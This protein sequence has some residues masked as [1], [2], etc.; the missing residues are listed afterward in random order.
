[1][2]HL[3]LQHFLNNY[4]E[5]SGISWKQAINSH[6]NGSQTRKAS[7]AY[8]VR[9]SRKLPELLVDF[10]PTENFRIRK[11]SANFA[12]HVNQQSGNGASRK[13]LPQTV[14]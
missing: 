5:Y 9:D 14:L 7:T 2:A 4:R 13:V 8:S 12:G 11:T 10:P 1:M 6:Q 3:K